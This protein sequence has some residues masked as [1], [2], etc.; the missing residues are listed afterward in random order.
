[1]SSYRVLV[2]GFKHETNTF[3]KQP[4]TMEDYKKRR[5]VYND[6]II[7]FFTGTKTEIG[8][9]IDTAQ[10]E[11]ITL[12][13]SIAADACPGGRVEKKVFNH[14]RDAIIKTYKENQPINGILLSLHG[15]MVLEGY[16]D[17]EGLLLESIRQVTG[18][19]LPIMVTLDLHANITEKMRFN[20]NGMFP[21][22]HYP[23]VDMYE[24][25]V[26]A[27]TNLFRMLRNEIKPVICIK[28][29]PILNPCLESGKPPHKPFL[30][31]ALEWEKNP[32]VISVSVVSGFPY[33]D[34]H[35]ATM[36]VIA[37]TNNDPELA[38]QITEE[39]GEAIIKKHKDFVKYT[40]PLEQAIRE[41]VE[42]PEG[43]VVIADVSDNTGA[44][45]PGDGT[46]VLRKMMEMNVKNAAFALITD[47]ETVE[48]AIEA[49]VGSSVKVSLGGK[50]MPEILGDPIEAEGIVKTITDGR[51]INKGPMSRGLMNDIGP[52][53]VIDFDGIEVIV[54]GRRIQP[55]D[56][57]IFRRMG[58]EPLDKKVLVVKSM[59]HFR[60][61]YTPLAKKIIDVD[62]PGPCP[63]NL[64]LLKLENVRRPVFPLDEIE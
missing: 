42:A 15:A 17:G 40:T 37:Q 39:I 55:F 56:P 33:A 38:S 49:G 29:L 27:A 57:E 12:I 25:G 53:V 19:D 44:G 24:R 47:S 4:T 51:F 13:P 43:P 23:H 62:V 32:Q 30:D 5:L 58:I 50:S 8:G 59:V 46:H 35:D 21:F 14:V 48:K 63:Q 28:K 6:E 64:R 10:K 45:A 16:P 34:I 54:S 20:S 22:D 11:G 52:T 2:A 18:Y 41:A 26:E 7:R 61:A 31:M 36:T 1:M 60:A 9:F 3:I